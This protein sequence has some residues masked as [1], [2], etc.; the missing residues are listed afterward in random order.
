M[1]L[2][3]GYLERTG[4]RRSRATAD[5]GSEY[6]RSQGRDERVLTQRM[7]HGA[8]F[9][10]LTPSMR[11]RQQRCDYTNPRSPAMHAPCAGEGS[12]HARTGDSWAR[13]DEAL[14]RQEVEHS[15]PRVS[16]R[17]RVIAEPHTE[18]RA[19]AQK[20][21]ERVW[22]VRVDDHGQIG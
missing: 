17:P 10:A 7:P 9:C 8:S 16:G 14:G 5:S 13:T 1:E 4:R 15:P 22:A 3:L 18:D 19:V 2:L 12:I 6:K 21:V 11:C 20:H